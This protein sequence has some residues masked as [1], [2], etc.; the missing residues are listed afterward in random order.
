MIVHSSST[1]Y[2]DNKAVVTPYLD[3]NKKGIERPIRFMFVSTIPH[4]HLKT[5]LLL[6]S[7]KVNP[8]HLPI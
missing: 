3:N 1:R 7:C 6:L 2:K 5:Q 8:A 4:N